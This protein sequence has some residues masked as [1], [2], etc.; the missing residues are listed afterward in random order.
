MHDTSTRSPGLTF[1]TPGADLL[2]GADRFVAEDPSVGHRGHVALEDV[3]VGA[4][5]RD[6]VDADDRVGVGLAASGLG[7]SSHALLAGTVV[8]ERLHVVPPL[9]M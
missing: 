1:L 6:G 7:T 2:D 3:Q 8:D 9:S 5:D 4:A